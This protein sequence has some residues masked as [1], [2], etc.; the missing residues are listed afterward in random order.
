[1]IGCGFSW[2]SSSQNPS[3]TSVSMTFIRDL[4][5][6]PN[7]V[8]RGEFERS[9]HRPECVNPSGPVAYADQ[10]GPGST[11]GVKRFRLAGHVAGEGGPTADTEPGVDVV[12]VAGDGSDADR[13]PVG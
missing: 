13:E 2:A 12:E 11:H 4:P 8:D 5:P 6:T 10:T 9:P 1:E 3:G 7:A